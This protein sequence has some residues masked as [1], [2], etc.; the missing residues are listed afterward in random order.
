MSIINSAN[1]WIHLCIIGSNLISGSSP[2]PAP[3]LGPTS[4]PGWQQVG[5]SNTRCNELGSC[6]LVVASQ[7]ECEQVAVTAGHEWYEYDSTRGCCNSLAACTLRTGTDY[8]WHLYALLALGA[9]A[10]CGGSL[11]NDL[12]LWLTTC[13]EISSNCMKSIFQ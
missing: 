6:N 7:A 11:M 1:Q 3:T 8:P 4:A 12:E 5:S 13:S 9:W 10:G 2:T